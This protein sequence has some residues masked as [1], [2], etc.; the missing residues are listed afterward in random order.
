MYESN[1]EM[2]AEMSANGYSYNPFKNPLGLSAFPSAIDD[3]VSFQDYME[4]GDI[5]NFDDR[6]R[7]IEDSML[8][9]W[10]ALEADPSAVIEAYIS[11]Q[12]LRDPIQK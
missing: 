5:G 1:R 9:E 7:W 11:R 8:P 4:N 3:V 10:Q 2:W 6:R 12:I